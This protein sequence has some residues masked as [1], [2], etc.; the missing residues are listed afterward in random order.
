MTYLAL[1]DEKSNQLNQQ[2]V[3]IDTMIQQFRQTIE[4]D[5]NDRT[6]NKIVIGLEGM[7]CELLEE[8]NQN[9]DLMLKY[10]LIQ[11]YLRSE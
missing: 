6:E 4:T 10:R 11:D 2:N 3:E 5:K 7:I 1:L 9:I 8:Q